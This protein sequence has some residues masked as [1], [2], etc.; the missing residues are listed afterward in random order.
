MVIRIDNLT[1]EEAVA[2]LQMLN[3]AIDLHFG[4]AMFSVRDWE[5]FDLDAARLSAYKKYRTWYEMIYG[6]E[7]NDA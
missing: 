4:E 2:I 7:T 1:D 5:Y 6:K 3:E